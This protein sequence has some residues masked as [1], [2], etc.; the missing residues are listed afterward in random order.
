MRKK[1]IIIIIIIALFIFLLGLF[2]RLEST[3][4]PGIPDS[5]KEYYRD[6]DGIAYMYEMDSYYNYRLT[7]N[8]ID[9]GSI[10]DLQIE[11]RPWDVHS[12]YPPGVPAEYPPLLIYVTAFFYRLVN[13]FSDTPL[14]TICFFL[15]AFIGPLAGVAIFLFTRR[16]INLYGAIAAGIFTVTSPLYTARTIS[17]Y[18]D[19]DIFIIIIPVLA[20][21][22][23]FEAIRSIRTKKRYIFTGLSVLLI[24][25]FSITWSGWYF[26]FYI[27][28]IFL[29]GYLIWGIR[30]R[31]NLIEIGSIL[32]IFT[33]GS[34]LLSGILSG[35]SDMAES[36]AAPF[37]LLKDLGRNP[38]S[39]WPDVY[40]LVSELQR[41]A[42]KEVI[43]EVGMAFFLGIL[44]FIWV[45]RVLVHKELKRRILVK[46]NWP[47]YIFLLVWLLMGLI[48]F[49]GGG[50]RFALLMMPPMII[51]SGV[52]IGIFSEYPKMIKEN[53]RIKKVNSVGLY[54]L[55]S[56]FIVHK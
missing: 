29:T 4:L 27:I 7:N 33:L 43:A 52:L 31:Y 2:I 12:Y 46:L 37:F 25:L 20:A 53:N 49:I 30:K 19:T 50:N 24:S 15:P 39:P 1:K 6:N 56:F 3:Q 42:F 8:L 38:W 41:P 26:L 5:D 14:I 54:A 34:I 45:F 55:N 51:S 11:G 17:G 18:F 16:F 21:W 44:G 23:L 47:F 28:L 22:S 35:F 40:S 48:I 13:L 10:G 9:N 36:L 32:I